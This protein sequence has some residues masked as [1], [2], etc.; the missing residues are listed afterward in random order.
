MIGR[1]LSHYRVT[2]ALG[3][4]GM[5]EVY[6]ATDTRLGRDVAIKVLPSELA[7]DAERLAR[8]ER[9]AKL[10]ASLNHTN[11]AHVY[12]FESATSGDGPTAHF[13]A[14]ELVDGEDLSERLKRGPIRLE[15]AL[16]VAKQIA[17]ALE[18]AHEKGIVHR[19][20][21]PA[22]VKLS[23][24]GKAKVLDF[25]LARAWEGDRDSVVGSSSSRRR[26]HGASGGSDPQSGSLL[27]T[28]ASTSLTVSPSKSRLPASI[29]NSTTPKAQMSAR[30]STV[31]PRACSGD[32]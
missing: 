21:K 16:L 29:S 24:D 7:G 14:M 17:E 10:L 11:I 22:N 9:E 2:A 19:D 3:A 28:D 32:M 23:L 4:G 8:F 20:L 1:T 13:L 31:R 18:E 6:R 5:G 27:R 15:D 12:G 26:P 30:L 25:G